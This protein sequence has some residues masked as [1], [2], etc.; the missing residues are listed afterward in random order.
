MGEEQHK[1]HRERLRRKFMSA[2]AGALHDYELV[3]LLLTY[4]IPL[5][6]V[7]PIA[8]EL[9][10]RHG[11][12]AGLMDA[13]P[14]ELEKTEGVGRN[15]AILISLIKNICAEYLAIK[16]RGKDSLS[17][18]SSVIDFARMKLAG[19][20]EESFMVVYLDAKN[21]VN[22]HEVINSG[23]VDQTVVYPR[24][25]IKKALAKDAS[26]I[27]IIH[28]HPSGVCEP[29]QSDIRIT[30]LIKEAAKTVN[31]RVVDHLVVGKSGYFSFVEGG[32]L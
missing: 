31:I 1:G 22:D 11:D 19:L 29:S 6:D 24:N 7:K 25:I 12:L 2:G 10:A 26:G 5:K 30:K 23:T 28:N 20:R 16:M 13:P 8:K 9:L 18:P 27:I 32:L 14:E 4:A 21:H 15:S 3:E 17:S